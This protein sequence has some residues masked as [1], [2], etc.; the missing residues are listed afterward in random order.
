M[1][2]LYGRVYFWRTGSSDSQSNVLLFY[3]TFFISGQWK[4]YIIAKGWKE[5]IDSDNNRDEHMKLK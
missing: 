3:A 5:Q 4:Q 2:L 1:K